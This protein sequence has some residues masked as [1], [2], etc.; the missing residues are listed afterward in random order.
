MA[1]FKAITNQEEFDAAIKDRLERAER[2]I[3]EEYKGWTSPDD[4]KKLAKAVEG[5]I[6]IDKAANLLGGLKKLF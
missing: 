6:N 4:L 3:R 2:K 1:D 5:K